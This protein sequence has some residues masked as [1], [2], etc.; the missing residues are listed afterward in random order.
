MDGKMREKVRPH[1][2]PLPPPSLGAVAGRQERGWPSPRLFVRASH[3]QGS[4]LSVLHWR[5]PRP[6]LVRGASGEVAAADSLRQG[7]CWCHL[8]VLVCKKGLLKEWGSQNQLGSF[9]KMPCSSNGLFCSPRF[10]SSRFS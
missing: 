8:W 5:L 10:F 4:Q 1:P 3:W 6:G 2:G 9:G 7:D